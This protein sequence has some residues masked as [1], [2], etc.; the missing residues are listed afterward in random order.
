MKKRLQGLITS[1]LIGTMVT[2]GMVFAKQTSETIKVIYDNNK[3]LIDGK[4]YQPTDANGNA[5]EPFISN[6]T[7][8]L[9]VRALAN[10]FDKEVDREAQ[11][12][13]VTLYDWLDQMGYADYETTGGFNKMGAISNETRTTQ[14]GKIIPK[15]MYDTIAIS[16]MEENI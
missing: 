2:S 6:E 1:V 12:S 5:V 3:I 11:T 7:T 9:P 10:A 4:E 8:Y 13:T 16:F 15:I 14:G